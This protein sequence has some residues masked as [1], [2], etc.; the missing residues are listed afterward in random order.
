MSVSNIKTDGNPEQKE[1]IRLI[2]E[3]PGSHDIVICTGQAGTG[4]NYVSIASAL[5]LIADKKYSKIYYGRNPVQCGEEMGFL[6]GDA[7]EKYEPFLEPL[8][9]NLM[10]LGKTNKHNPN[11][12]LAKIEALPIA[13]LRGRSFEDAV[14][15]IDECQNLDINTLQTII[16][17][18]GNYTK[19]I[20][21]G[22]YEQ[23]DD[24]K[25][26][27]YPKCDFEELTNRLTTLFPDFVAHIELKKSMRN[28]MTTALDKACFDLKK[29][30][31][32]DRQNA[33]INRKQ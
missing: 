14:V 24:P 15:I 7:E 30:L 2:M 4:K 17:R 29:E 10:H 3:R 6:A 8:K 31:F 25:Q 27:R 22:S 33:L 1:L 19:L 23:I 13:F 16:T 28:P 5:Q 32:A 11:D 12:Y 18:M 21:L 9:D 20:L 26:A